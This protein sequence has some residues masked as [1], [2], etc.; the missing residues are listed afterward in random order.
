MR[1]KHE[2][3][4]GAREKEPIFAITPEMPPPLRLPPADAITPYEN[5][6]RHAT[7]LITTIRIYLCAIF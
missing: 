3:E 1:E 2:S 7:P 4:R 5:I 6:A